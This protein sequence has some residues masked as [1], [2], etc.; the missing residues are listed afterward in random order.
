[1]DNLEMVKRMEK[2][3][4]NMQMEISILESLKMERWMAM[5]YS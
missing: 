1:M 5:Q 4:L 3:H 2:E